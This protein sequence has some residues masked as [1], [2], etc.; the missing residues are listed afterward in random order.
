MVIEEAHGPHFGFVKT[1]ETIKSRLFCYGMYQDIKSYCTS[2]V[3]CKKS[4]QHK[5]LKVPIQKMERNLQISASLHID[6]VGRLPMTVRKNCI[7]LIIV[8]I[9]QAVPLRNVESQTIL[10][11]LNKY[12]GAYGLASTIVADIGK[13]F[14][15]AV[16][17]EYL[18]TLNIDLHFTSN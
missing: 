13:Y 3:R 9:D 17:K 16:F 11:I 7:I 15:S 10:N 5:T 6:G 14:L 4:K 1:C 18:K 8:S 12:F 2:C